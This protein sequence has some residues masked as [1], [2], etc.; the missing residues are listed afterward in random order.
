MEKRTRPRRLTPAQR[1]RQEIRQLQARYRFAGPV[2]KWRI[3]QR[4]AGLA[5][6]VLGEA[7]QGQNQ[8][9]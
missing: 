6:V 1:A 4:I 8:T 5:G 7:E 9:Q 2:E 3:R